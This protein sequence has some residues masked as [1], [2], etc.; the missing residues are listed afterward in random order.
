MFLFIKIKA[1]YKTSVTPKIDNIFIFIIYIVM[2]LIFGVLH[3]FCILLK[4]SVVLKIFGSLKAFIWSL[5]LLIF[6]AIL[7]NIMIIS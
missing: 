3:L 5:F 1:L 7:S 2:L 4:Y 6:I